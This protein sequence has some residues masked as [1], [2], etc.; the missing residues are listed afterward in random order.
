[1]TV[2]NFT[3]RLKTRY[4]KFKDDFSSISDMEERLKGFSESD[5]EKLWEAFIDEYVFSRIPR[6]ADFN[7]IAIN[8]NLHRAVKVILENMYNICQV[9]NTSYSSAGRI[10]PT[11]HKTTA[12]NVIAGEYPRGFKTVREDCGQCIHYS[13]NNTAGINCS[14]FGSYKVNNMYACKMCICVKCCNETH[15]IHE[16]SMG[17][18]D[19]FDRLTDQDEWEDRLLPGCKAL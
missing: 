11:C 12:I 2:D 10:C 15:A 19:K 5:L 1:M 16:G 7:K 18:T 9:C 4:P 14:G 13:G 3:N 6:W 17:Y 8:C